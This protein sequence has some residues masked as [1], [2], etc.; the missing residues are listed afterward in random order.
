[1]PTAKIYGMRAHLQTDL[2]GIAE[3][4]F[5]LITL[6]DDSRPEKEVCVG[7]CIPVLGLHD[8]PCLKYTGISNRPTGIFLFRSQEDIMAEPVED[9]NEFLDAPDDLTCAICLCQPEPVDL[10]IIK[11]CEHNYCGELLS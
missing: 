1:M 10:A 4:D 9:R 6:E 2:G 3:T 8:D 7:P 11:G 5:P